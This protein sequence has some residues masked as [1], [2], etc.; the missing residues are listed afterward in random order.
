MNEFLNPICTVDTK[1]DGI[2]TETTPGNESIPGAR[3]LAGAIAS[4]C[5]GQM[6]LLGKYP[7]EVGECLRKR[8]GIS[9][10][11]PSPYSAATQAID[12][13]A[14]SA[15]A[16]AADLRSSGQ[17][18]YETVLVTGVL[19]YLNDSAIV[20]FLQNAWKQLSCSGRLIVCIPNQDCINGHGQLQ[21]F[22]RKK[23]RRL[24]KFFGRP[25]MVTNQPY[26]WLVMYV[27]T[28]TQISRSTR[29]RYRVIAGFCRGSVI[30]LGC[31]TGALTE[32]ISTRNPQIIG[33]D[34]NRSKIDK[35]RLS[36]P[37]IN[38]IQNDILDLDLASQRFDTVVLAEV[39]EH[40]PAGIGSRILK[41]AWSLVSDGGRFLISVPNEDC[42]PHPNHLC[43]FN[44]DSL[45]E[46]LC[47]FGQP[48]LISEQP[49]KYL[50]M[51]VD[52]TIQK[53]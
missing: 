40:V 18:G 19:E 11:Q 28:Q 53:I 37:H 31:G 6:L 8:K 34:M 33:V 17:T 52:R 20:D 7:R 27:D 49:Y 15:S 46:L 9:L 13:P 26:K 44:R 51:Y 10:H 23:L 22:D 39:L 45:S 29:E 42:V 32:T 30:E 14:M 5:R 2:C 12:I 25:K 41:K 1:G 3:R 48:V 50:L 35:A 24:L 38:F 16:I 43:A 47:P 21:S 4:Q 36:Y